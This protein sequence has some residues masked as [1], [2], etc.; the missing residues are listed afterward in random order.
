MIQVLYYA[1][2][3]QSSF[4]FGVDIKNN[5]VLPPICIPSSSFVVNLQWDAKKG[6]IFALAGFEQNNVSYVFSFGSMGNLPT[7]VS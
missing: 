3:F 2:D 6:R 5:S 1:A 7:K 4:I